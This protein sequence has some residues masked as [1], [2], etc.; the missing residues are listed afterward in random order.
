MRERERQLAEAEDAEFE[1]HPV[2]AL[3]V[4]ERN[5]QQLADA[6]PKHSTNWMPLAVGLGIVAVVGVAGVIVYLLLRRDGNKTSTLGEVDPRY[7][8]PPPAMPA[9]AAPQI[10][11][12]NA[13]GGTVTAPS[14]APA[15]PNVEPALKPV[16][17]PSTT[18]MLHRLPPATNAVPAALATAAAHAIEV[19]VAILEP[20]GAVA[21]L[22]F[23]PD[24][25]ERP[26]A[27][28][29]GEERRIRIDRGQTLYGKGQSGYVTVTVASTS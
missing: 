5:A 14:A 15:A 26:M 6:E 16:A 22:A 12:I 1:D 9:A 23:S 25:A 8:L 10:Y 21:L 2:R 13:G 28:R 27:L 19:N 20:T 4:R 3:A 11:V 24:L 17:I 18:P 7:F 29:V